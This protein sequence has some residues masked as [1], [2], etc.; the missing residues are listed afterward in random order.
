MASVLSRLSI[1]LHADTAA[2]RRDMDNAQ[3]RLGRF[4]V[5]AKQA[6]KVAA[7]G[8]AAGA[9]VAAAAIGGIAKEQMAAAAEFERFAQLSNTT[10]VEFQKLAAGAARYG[11]EA[12]KLS[13]IYKDMNDRVGDFVQTGGGPLADFFENIAPKVG[14]TAKS[15]K[16]LSGPESLQLFYSSLEKANL[17]QADMVFY[18]ESIASDSTALQPLLANNGQGFKELGDQAQKAGGI[19]SQSTLDS[20]RKLNQDLA[21]LKTSFQGVKVQIYEAVLPALIQAAEW[22]KAN[23]DEI[24]SFING[25]VSVVK[26]MA[27]VVKIAFTAVYNAGVFLGEGIAKLV[28]GFQTAKQKISDTATGIKNAFVN[29]PSAMAS[30][31][32]DIINGL[33]NGIKDRAA[34]AVNAV[35]D[36]ASNMYQGVK[37]FFVVRSPSRLMRSL[38]NDIGEGLVVGVK[39]KKSDAYKA[40]VDVAK[41]LLSGIESTRK[42]IALFGNDSAVAAFDYD[43][44]VGKYDNVAPELRARY[45]ADLLKIENM[46]KE[47]RA[48]AA[49]NASISD[50]ANQFQSDQA[51]AA[52]DFNNLDVNGPQTEVEKLRLAYENKMAIVDRYEQMHTDKKV[53]AENARVSLTEGFNQS[54]QELEMQKQ[55]QTVGAVTAMFGMALGETSKGYKAMFAV[56]KAYDFVQAQSA[57]FTAI[58]KAWSSAPFPANIPAVATTTLQTGIIPAAIQ[59]LNPKGFMDGGYTGNYPTNMPVGPVHGKEFVAHAAATSKY[60]SELEAMNDGTYQK[61]SNPVI[62]M[63][64]EN[65][66]DATVRQERDPDGRIRLIVGEEVKRQAF[67]NRSDLHRG[68]NANYNMRRNL[69]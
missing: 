33:I 24:K 39:D 15:F 3:S 23:Q 8:I 19:M 5:G 59:A 62:N 16:N 38:G 10:A 67:N 54:V 14:V 18:M 26:V 34:A 52:S 56:Q 55:A 43:V 48:R 4:G 47:E 1:L 27:P 58:A 6:M 37:N 45:R 65:H 57:S 25:I 30:I 7:V 44:L 66:T 69:G 2:F 51:G 64:I 53:Q 11:I 29:L 50:R 32:R 40:A 68:L 22:F 21:S 20:T 28:I 41:S 9:G 35:K 31:G 61:D 42:E 13:D 49:I 36:T 63:T 46:K 12:D 60:R 17:S